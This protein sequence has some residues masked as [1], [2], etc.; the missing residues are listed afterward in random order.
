MKKHCVDIILNKTFHKKFLCVIFFIQSTIFN[1]F[2]GEPQ[3]DFQKAN[4][5]YKKSDYE[6]AVKTYEQLLK[7]SSALA[8]VYYNLGNCYYKTGNISK[9]ILNYEHAL[10]L[11]PDDEDANF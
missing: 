6:N 11:N 4:D 9:S 3:S 5:Y 7:E 1:S 10:K 8:E 2:A